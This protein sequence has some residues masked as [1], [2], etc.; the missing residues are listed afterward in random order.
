[1]KTSRKRVVA[2][3]GNRLGHV[4]GAVMATAVMAACFF[5][6]DADA[7]T[8]AT[9]AGWAFVVSYGATYFL[10]RLVLRT[11]LFEVVEKKKQR[12]VALKEQAAK[13]REQQT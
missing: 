11:T 9:R 5:Y 8:T 1:M 4:V 6:R 2:L 12:K 7:Y 10:A 3:D 13:A